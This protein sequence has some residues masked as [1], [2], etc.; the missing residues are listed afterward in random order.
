MW[1]RSTTVKWLS[2]RDRVGRHGLSRPGT[3]PTSCDRCRQGHCGLSRFASPEARAMCP[4]P[5]VLWRK[6]SDART[7]LHPGRRLDL[8]GAVDRQGRVSASPEPLG[9]DALDMTVRDE[10]D[11][12]HSGDPLRDHAAAGAHRTQA[13]RGRVGQGIVSMRSDSTLGVSTAQRC[14]LATACTRGAPGRR[15]KLGYVRHV[16]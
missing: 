12:R 4:P 9:R 1:L 11:F 8:P 13:G 14:F 3:R 6:R 7:E 5:L 2:W 10:Q 15:F 16:R